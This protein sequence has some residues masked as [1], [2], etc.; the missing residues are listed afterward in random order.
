MIGQGMVEVQQGPNRKLG[1][2]DDPP[3]TLSTEP[4]RT[5]R[6]LGPVAKLTWQANLHAAWCNP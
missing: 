5:S 4:I 2:G 6:D 3:Q 1:S